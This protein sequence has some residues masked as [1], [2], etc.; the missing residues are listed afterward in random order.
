MRE[1]ES[2]LIVTISFVNSPY[3]LRNVIREF[4][5]TLPSVS[6]IYYQLTIN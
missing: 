1:I 3:F 6:R 2:E 5:M 4:T